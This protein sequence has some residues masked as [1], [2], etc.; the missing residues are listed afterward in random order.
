MADANMNVKKCE[1][2]IANINALIAALPKGTQ[3]LNESWKILKPSILG[4]HV[5]STIEEFADADFKNALDYIIKN[6]SKIISEIELLK[7]EYK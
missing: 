5:F 1:Q 7:K 3:K 4:G 6:F 2:H